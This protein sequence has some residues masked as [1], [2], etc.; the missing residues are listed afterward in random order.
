[1]HYLPLL[2]LSSLKRKSTK[3]A[4]RQSFMMEAKHIDIK[5]PSKEPTNLQSKQTHKHERLICYV[6]ISVLWRESRTFIIVE[7]KIH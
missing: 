2:N 4:R 1:M 3:M 7:E 5:K 6:L